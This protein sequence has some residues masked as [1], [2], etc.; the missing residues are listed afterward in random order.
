MSTFLT[1]KA[2]EEKLTDIIW[3][4]K[5]YVAVISPFIKL[6][7]FVRQVF[8]KVK[9][10]PEVHLILVFGKNEGYKQKSLCKEDFEYFKEFKNIS[11]LYNKNLHA[12]YY[13]N[14]NE[15]LITS[16]NLYDYSMI[17]NI[18]FGVHFIDN[19]LNPTDKLFKQSENY[20]DE[21]IFEKCEVVF[22]KEPF[23]TDKYFGLKKEYTNSM[24]TYDIS[25]DF[26][27]GKKYEIKYLN[28]IDKIAEKQENTFFEKPIRENAIEKNIVNKKKENG[29]CI[30]TGV[31]IPYNQERPFCLQAYKMWSKYENPNFP[32]NYCHKTGV[33]SNGKTNM[34]HPVL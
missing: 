16:L 27:K 32:E 33:K 14:E 13:C 1:G 26:F 4:A 30:R 12:K 7:S 3:G 11:I 24:I 31:Q 5:K 6:D 17:N 21:L 19:I 2:L 22:T 8:D 29:Y 15:G 34:A 20:T 9:S 28:D 18:E 25:D 10:N 23:Y